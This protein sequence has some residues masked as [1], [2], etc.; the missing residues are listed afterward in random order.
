MV[1]FEIAKVVSYKALYCDQCDISSR[2]TAFRRRMSP[3]LKSTG[4]GQF[5][6]KFVDDVIDRCQPDFNTI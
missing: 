3:T 6:A 2:S 4:V 5:V 1:Q